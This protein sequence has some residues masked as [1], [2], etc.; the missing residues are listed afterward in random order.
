MKYKI[1]SLPKNE[2]IKLLKLAFEKLQDKINKFEPIERRLKESL[3]NHAIDLFIFGLFITEKGLKE[4]FE[5]YKERIMK[6]VQKQ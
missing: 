5:L 4:E 2:I 6:K 3:E 1:D